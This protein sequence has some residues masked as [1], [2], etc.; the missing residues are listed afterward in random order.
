MWMVQGEDR[1]DEQGSSEGAVSAKA[2]SKT[3]AAPAQAKPRGSRGAAGAEVEQASVD[4]GSLI[5][6]SLKGLKDP[7]KGAVK[8]RKE[9]VYYRKASVW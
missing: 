6:G 3:D 5:Q 1:G 7:Q 8:P 2:V 4:I 9:I